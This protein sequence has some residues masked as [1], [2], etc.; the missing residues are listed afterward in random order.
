MCMSPWAIW[1]ENWRAPPLRERG[2]REGRKREGKEGEERE[3]ER[4]RGRERERERR[5]ARRGRELRRDVEREKDGIWDMV[6]ALLRRGPR[7]VSG[8]R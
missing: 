8:L 2:T 7:D 3:G 1:R 5:E 4:E 6:E